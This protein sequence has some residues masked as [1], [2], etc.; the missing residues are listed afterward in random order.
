MISTSVIATSLFIPQVRTKRVSRSRLVNMLN[1]GM[2]RKLTIVTAPAGYGKITLLSLDT[3][4]AGEPD[5]V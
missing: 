3:L 5:F 4:A 2:N 1:E